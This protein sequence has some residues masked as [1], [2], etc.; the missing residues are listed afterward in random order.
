MRIR[1]NWQSV[2]ILGLMAGVLSS[3]SFNPNVRKQKYF[4]SGE[5]Y[6]AKGQYREA[7]IQFNNAIE[8]DPGFA[9]AHLQLAETYL[10][11]RQQDRAEQEFGEV[12][13]LRPGDYQTRI[14]M[15]NLLV[16]DHKFDQ[17]EEQIKLLLQQRPADP[18]VHSLEAALLAGEGKVP[19]AIAETQKSIA[20]APGKWEPYMS[21]AL[22]QMKAGDSD[23]AEASLKKVIELDPK[24]D[25]ARVVLGNF[26]ESQNHLNEAE[27]EFREAM[28]VST[29]SMEP[30]EALAKLLIAEGKNPAAEQVLLQA[31][32]DLPNNP[33]SALDLSNFYFVTGDLNKAVAE[34][35]ALY[36]QRPSD[37][38]V[39]KKYIQLLIQV[40][41]Y[42][43]AQ[44][45]DEEIL[46]TSPNDSDAL[47]YR[48]QMQIS[49][50]HAADAVQTL[51]GV[52]RN[53]PNNSEA[54]YALGVAFDKQGDPDRA[55]A[56]WQAALQLNPN[57]LEAELAVA[58]AAM[59]RGDM[60]TLQTA[61]SQIIR[62]QPRAPDGYA[63]RA[64]SEINLKELGNAEGDV[65]KAIQVAPQSGFGYVQL[66]NLRFVQ[67]RYGEAVEAYENALGRDTGSTDALRGLVN[68]YMAEKQVDKAIATVNAQI[69]K[70]PA[71]SDFYDLLGS[72]L[73]RGKK[74]LNGAEAALEKST[75]LN[76]HSLAGWIQLCEVRAAKG[77]F[78]Q[79]IHTDEQAIKA[80]PGRPVL[81]LL[82]GDLYESTSDWTDAERAYQNALAIDSQDPVA[83]NGLA[84]AMTHTGGNLDV[85]LS[86]AQT[87]RLGCLTLPPSSIRSVGFITTRAHMRSR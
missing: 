70:S 6:F 5:Q 21:L 40:K 27:Q 1:G 42:D 30:R 54:H 59:E 11:L 41:R 55:E 66:G 4:Q 85:A 60:H 15:T 17:A 31:R 47:L 72:L 19:E 67:K 71:N 52:I 61:A 22:L 51:Q 50:G 16:A 25:E 79:A 82:L 78:D 43:E 13:R 20:L 48:S 74:D 84:R 32:H 56:E 2:V 24:S 64:L 26:Y 39:K 10:K 65:Q 44:R 9:Y 29:Q 35:D 28:A 63:L 34:Y 83:C 23:A 75:M 58:H 69:A 3:C 77:Q 33:Q 80:N 73:F 49:E 53:L 46:R 37:L 86:L 36:Q 57:S 12:V 18:A 81:Y 7:A 62:L 68:T 76:Q 8:I 87:A 45:L 14:A 38:Q